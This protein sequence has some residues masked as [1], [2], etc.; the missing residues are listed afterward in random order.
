[1]R[2]LKTSIS[3]PEYLTPYSPE[4]EPESFP[5]RYTKK[6]IGSKLACRRT[7]PVNGYSLDNIR[8]CWWQW[9]V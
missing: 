6:K 1:M 8:I 5:W 9:I 2:S 7:A 3:I 4:Y